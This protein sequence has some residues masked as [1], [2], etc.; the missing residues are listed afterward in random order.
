T[1]RDMRTYTMT[2]IISLPPNLAAPDNSREG[3]LQLRTPEGHLVPRCHVPQRGPRAARSVPGDA[4]PPRGGK[5]GNAPRDCPR[6]RSDATAPP[7]GLSAGDP[8]RLRAV[9]RTDGPRRLQGL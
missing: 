8:E 2:D 9:R 3:C 4:E 7:G 1:V 5:P 6:L